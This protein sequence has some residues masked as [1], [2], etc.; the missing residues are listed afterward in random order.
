MAVGGIRPSPEGSSTRRAPAKAAAGRQCLDHSRRL[1]HLP[2][3]K[4]C[5]KLLGSS[6]V[7]AVEGDCNSSDLK[8]EF[9]N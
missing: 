4:Y 7:V 2:L 5:C 3:T 8:L 6:E 1:L 9:N